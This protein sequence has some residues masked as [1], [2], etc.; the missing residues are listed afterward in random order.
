MKLIEYVVNNVIDKVFQGEI[1]AVIRLKLKHSSED[2]I[3][4]AIT[5][6]FNKDT[7]NIPDAIEKIGLVV[8]YDMGW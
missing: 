6:Y 8:S 5:A 4:K 7:T 3:N 1:E 2:K